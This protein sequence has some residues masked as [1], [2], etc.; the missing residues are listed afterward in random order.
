MRMIG[1]MSTNQVVLVSLLK[2]CAG[3]TLVSASDEHTILTF[4]DGNAPFP[5]H[6]TAI[7]AHLFLHARLRHVVDH[8]PPKIG[9]T[10]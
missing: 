4:H 5:K 9:A 2:R 8:L 3:T 1:S 7:N 10:P 6:R